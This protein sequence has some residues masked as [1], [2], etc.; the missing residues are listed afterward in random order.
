MYLRTLDVVIWKHS[1]TESIGTQIYYISRSEQVYRNNTIESYEIIVYS[2][3]DV[4][5][6]ALNMQW[7][8]RPSFYRLEYYVN[9]RG[10]SKNLVKILRRVYDKWK[11]HW[12]N[13]TMAIREWTS[14]KSRGIILEWSLY[15]QYTNDMMKLIKYLN[16][17]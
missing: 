15:L 17:I 5:A 14:I 9:C 3:I 16:T 11:N 10:K 6:T 1:V 2:S 4:I 7:K 12:K 13:I 8:A